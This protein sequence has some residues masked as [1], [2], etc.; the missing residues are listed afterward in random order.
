M[1]VLRPTLS[2]FTTHIICIIELGGA[3]VILAR[4][5]RSVLRVVS[6]A[7]TCRISDH[8]CLPK[9]YRAPAQSKGWC[10]HQMAAPMQTT[11]ATIM[12]TRSTWSALV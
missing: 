2:L 5:G 12:H 11:T 4:S 6:Q 8:V 9:H 3:L 1:R 7:G 10:D